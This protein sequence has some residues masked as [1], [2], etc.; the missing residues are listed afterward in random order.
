MAYA[1]T[2]LKILL[3]VTSRWTENQTR[4]LSGVKE[5]PQFAH[6]VRSE[7]PRNYGAKYPNAS[8]MTW[9]GFDV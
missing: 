3:S 9:L 2:T 1:G 8:R 4:S 5:K 7:S 6:H